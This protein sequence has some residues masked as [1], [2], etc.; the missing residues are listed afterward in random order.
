MTDRVTINGLE[1]NACGGSCVWCGATFQARKTGGKPKRFCSRAHS[2]AYSR[3]LWHFASRLAQAGILALINGQWRLT[4]AKQS[5]HVQTYES[6]MRDG[7]TADEKSLDESLRY[8]NVP[9][10]SA[11]HKMDGAL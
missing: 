2:H 9:S 7:V 8:T 5:E 11:R 3:S 1:N 10:L 4:S 6:L